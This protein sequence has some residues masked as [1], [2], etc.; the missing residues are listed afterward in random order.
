MPP[1]ALATSSEDTGLKPGTR[2]MTRSLTIVMDISHATT[3][4]GFLVLLEVLP[5]PRQCLE[6]KIGLESCRLRITQATS[7]QHRTLMT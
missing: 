4:Q 2:V 6:N 7:L 5:R 1:N 3:L